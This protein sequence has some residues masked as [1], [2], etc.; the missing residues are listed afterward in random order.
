MQNYKKDVQMNLFTEEDQKKILN[1]GIKYLHVLK[2]CSPKDGINTY[3]A[4]EKE[5]FR[6]VF[7]K[8]KASLSIYSFIP[9]SGAASR[10][11]KDLIFKNT[12]AIDLFNSNKSKFPFNTAGDIETI[13]SNLSTVPKALIPFHKEKNKTIMPF[14]KQLMIN[15]ELIGCDAKIH[16]TISESHISTFEDLA[17][18]LSTMYD[19]SI[20][21]ST[22]N[23]ETNTI[24]VNKQGEVFFDQNNKVV[25]RPAGHGA[26]LEN[27]NAVKADIVLIQNIDNVPNKTNFNTV[28][29]HK[30]FLTGLL[31]DTQN[32][33]FRALS[34]IDN[35]TFQLRTYTSLFKDL[36]LEMEKLDLKTIQYLL[37]RPLRVCGMV[38]NTGEPGGGPFWVESKQGQKSKQII[39]KVHLDTTNNIQKSIVDASTH[40]NPVNII[41]G[42]KNYK[43]NS[44]NLNE[45]VDYDTCIINQKNI[46]NVEVKTLEYPGLWNG[47]MAGWNSVFAE[48]P[49]ETFTPVKTIFDLLKKEHQE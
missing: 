12:K 43:G 2:A 9:A 41:C 37:N 46:G 31:I 24:C 33:I 16:F 32:L 35:K 4:K 28:I 19:T 26:L 34:E 21:F 39:E 5:Y 22:Q 47:S 13:I 18:N 29:E 6:N 40:F 30:R 1:L 10:M 25:K 38:P 23:T 7:L 11:F 49:K 44:F 14:E 8:Q 42:L 17:K 27:L 3:N 36:G 15:R 45:F 48:V 20:Q